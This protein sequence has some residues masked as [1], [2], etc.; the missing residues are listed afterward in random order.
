MLSILPL[1]ILALL[2]SNDVSAT[3]APQPEPRGL[4]MNLRRRV[5]APRSAEELGV[6]AKNQREGL[7]AKYGGK[8]AAS[9]RSTGTNLL[10]N[11]NGDSSFYGS[12][13]I[14]TPAV[15]YDVILDTGSA[16]LWV[17]GSTCKVGCSSSI[18]KFDPS[19]SSTFTNSSTSFA[20]QYGSGEAVGALGKD[21]VQMA[22]FAVSNQVF[23]VCDEVSQGLLTS[24]VSGLLGLA[25]QSIASSNAVPFA[26]TLG[27]GS[28]WDSPVMAFQLT[29]FLN[30]SN[31]Q[32]EEG[33]S[34]SLPSGED[35]YAAIDTGTTLVG[36][37]PD[38]IS[39]LYAQIPDSQPGTGNFDGYFLYPC[40][41]SVTVTLSFGGKTWSVSPADFLLEQADTRGETCVGSFFSLTTGDTAP[42]WI[43]GD[44]FLK[45]VYSVFRFSP[46]SVGFAQLSAYSL[47]INGD[48]DLKVPTPTIGSVS[49]EAT[50]GPGTID[51]N[52]NA[53]AS[54]RPASLLLHVAPVVVMLAVGFWA[55]L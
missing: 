55:D 21:K 10:V 6:W 7:I 49:A 35:S 23:A 26:Q 12:L 9:K 41:T 8:S 4:S 31:V 2:V 1:S 19:S 25:W 34:V 52:S 38:Q 24:P 54:L 30:A 37:P 40:S 14:G 47:S 36:G 44:T 42:P 32:D 43:V 27:T 20:I 45:N 28:S 50:A 15:S 11:Q 51:S 22:G 3:P 18:P 33:N 13:A 17:A 48:T 39:A 5:R 16:D 29:R 46:P 53:A